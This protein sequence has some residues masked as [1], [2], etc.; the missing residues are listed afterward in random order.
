MTPV[1]SVVTMLMS[2]LAVVRPAVAVVITM[3]V[4]FKSLVA[5]VRPLVGAVGGKWWSL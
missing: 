1:H 3:M 4:V 2:V 5:F